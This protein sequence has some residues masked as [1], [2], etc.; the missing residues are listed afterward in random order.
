MTH[1]IYLAGP[2]SGI[3]EFNFPAFNEAAANLRAQGHTVFSPAERDIERHGG[4][5]ISVGNATGCQ[6]TAAAVHALLT[7]PCG[8]RPG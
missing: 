2:M 5:D 4:V 7:L 6:A 3:A 8:V 1:R